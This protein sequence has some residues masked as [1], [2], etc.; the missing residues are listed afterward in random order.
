MKKPSLKGIKRK[1]WDAF[2]KYIRMKYADEDGYV[3]CVTCPARKHWKQMQAGH[4]VDG[5]GGT[6]LYDESLVYPQCY[7]C[8]CIL[9]GNKNRYTVFMV[10]TY[11]YTMDQIEELENKRK[12]V[13]PLKY[14]DHEEIYNKYNDL[15]N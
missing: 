11:G 9:K 10:K 12:V 13:T 6:V 2:S 3:K 14:K 15:L 7:I 8:N 5:R 4:Y 1:A